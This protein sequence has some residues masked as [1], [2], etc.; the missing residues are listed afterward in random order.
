VT[1]RDDPPRLRRG[2]ASLPRE[3]ALALESSP[4]EEATPEDLE[5]VA[6][7]VRREL[8]TSDRKSS[9]LHRFPKRR[10]PLGTTIA[11]VA[12]FALGAG[13]GV[14]VSGGVFVATRQAFWAPKDSVKAVPSA[15]ARVVARSARPVPK[16][17][18]AGTAEPE[19][20]PVP[21]AQA[22][23][24]RPRVSAPAPVASTE[25]PSGAPSPA[26][27]LALLNRAQSLLGQ[28][29]ALSLMLASD[30]QRRFRP[31]TLVQEREVIAIDALLRLGQRPAAEARAARFREQFPASVHLRRVDVLLG[32]GS[33]SPPDHN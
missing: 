26:E 4:E 27:E 22:G 25:E 15:K 24:L 9:M 3:L 20:P 2:A 30:H 33:S 28:N 14:L 19:S 12:T 8:E 29:P 11:F 21:S 1:S 7:A 31:G 17:E 32:V 5:Q 18:A 23:E 16:N 13:A 6:S 10:A